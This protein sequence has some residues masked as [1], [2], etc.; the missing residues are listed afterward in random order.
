MHLLETAAGVYEATSD[1]LLQFV[2][3]ITEQNAN[4]LGQMN[5]RIGPF[6]NQPN[7]SLSPTSVHVDNIYL[8][9]NGI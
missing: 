1:N 7:L 9:G 8:Y 2:I 5:D 4:E 3:N 6:R